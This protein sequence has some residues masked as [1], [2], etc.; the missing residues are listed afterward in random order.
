[1]EKKIQ[2]VLGLGLAVDVIAPSHG[3]IWRKDPLQIVN[4]YREWAAQRPSP[5]PRSCTRHVGRTRRMA[6]AIGEGLAAEGTDC[7]LIDLSVTD[8]N[9]ALVEAHRSRTLAVGSRP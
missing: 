6:E 2:E 3:V 7:K 8:L 1:V 4:K 5:G 9:D